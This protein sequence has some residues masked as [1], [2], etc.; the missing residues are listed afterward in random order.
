MNTKSRTA[1]FRFWH[2]AMLIFGLGVK[3]TAGVFAP[4]EIWSDTGGQPINAHGGGVLF[5]EGNYYWYGEFKTGVTVLPE[6]NQHWGGTLVDLTGV[7]CYSS[8]NLT[9]WKNRR[10]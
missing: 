1:F 7:S 2:H 9:E 8:T 10:R 3:V 4:G 5:H 6:C